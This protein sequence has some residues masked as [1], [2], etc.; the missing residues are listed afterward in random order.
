M[1]VIGPTPSLT[2]GPTTSLVIYNI[3]GEVGMEVVVVVFI[4]GSFLAGVV[5]GLLTRKEE[6]VGWEEQ[7]A[8]W[9]KGCE[10]C[11]CRRPV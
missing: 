1:Q 8:A 10:Q 4:V 2:A 11:R 7:S 6:T 9:T 5:A 3:G